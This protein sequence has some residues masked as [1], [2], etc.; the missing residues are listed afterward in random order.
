MTEEG[1]DILDGLNEELGNGLEE[2][3]FR[4]NHSVGGVLGIKIT[5]SSSSTDSSIRID[6]LDAVRNEA[7]KGRV[8]LIHAELLL[9]L[10]DLEVDLP[11]IL[12]PVLGQRTTPSLDV[13]HTEPGLRNWRLERE[14]YEEGRTSEVIE[15]LLFRDTDGGEDLEPDVLLTRNGE[16]GGGTY[17][18]KERGMLTPL[19]AIQSISFSHLFQSQKELE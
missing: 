5:P 4:I 19:R 9:S 2:R 11:L 8:D 18:V 12:D 3:V 6:L 15:N 10:G 1:K 7:S 13:T 14:S 16:E 17:P